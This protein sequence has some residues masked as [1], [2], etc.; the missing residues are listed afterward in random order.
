M[1]EQNQGSQSKNS[2]KNTS[3]KVLEKGKELEI[4]GKNEST[5]DSVKKRQ[6]RTKLPERKVPQITFDSW[7]VTAQRRHGFNPQLKEVIYKHFKA[8]G[9]LSSKRFDEGLKD[10]GI[11]S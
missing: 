7:W 11:K 1:T 3:K 6:L 5:E 8:R 10:F 4:V 2:S 9:F